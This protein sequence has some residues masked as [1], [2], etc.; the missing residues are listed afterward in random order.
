MRRPQVFLMDEPLSDLDAK[1]RVQ[2]RAELISLHASV[3]ITTIYVTHDQT[4][5]MTLGD[6]VVVMDKGVVQQVDTPDR[7]YR[8]PDNTFVA[9]F[10]GSPAMNFFHGELETSQRLGPHRFEL[11]ENVTRDLRTE[12]RNV[13]VGVRKTSCSAETTPSRSR[14]RSR[15]A[16][17]S[18]P[19][20]SSTCAQQTCLSP[21]S[22]LRR[23]RAT[24]QAP[25]GSPARSWPAST[26]NSRA[27]QAT[28]SA[29]GSTARRS[30]S[31]THSPVPP[32]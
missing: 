22:A 17:A 14:R 23:R 27:A 20:C 5:A 12:Q 2:M 7:L 9:G 8:M 3:G 16:N 4:E 15:S 10:I 32:C 30:D 13:I 18:G 24:H 28:Q 25:A 19:R 6:R 21:M 26:Q 29:S 31:L 1:L 11:P